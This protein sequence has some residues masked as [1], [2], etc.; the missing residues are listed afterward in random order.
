MRDAALDGHSLGARLLKLPAPLLIR[1]LSRQPRNAH[2]VLEPLH[3]DRRAPAPT[4]PRRAAARNERAAAAAPW[5]AASLA[6]ARCAAGSRPALPDRTTPPRRARPAARRAPHGRPAGSCSRSIAP[7][8]RSAARSGPGD[9]ASP[10]R[11]RRAAPPPPRP[12]ATRAPPPAARPSPPPPWPLAAPP[13]R[14]RAPR[15]PPPP[16]SASP[17]GTAAPRPSCAA[18][19]VRLRLRLR[20]RSASMRRPSSRSR[21]RASAPSASRARVSSCLSSP[22]AAS[23]WASCTPCCCRSWCGLGRGL[24]WGHRGGSMVREGSIDFAVL[25]VR[26]AH[27][28][29]RALD[30]LAHVQLVARRHALR[31]ALDVDVLPRAVDRVEDSPGPRGAASLA[32]QLSDGLR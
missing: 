31:L 16:R 29:H 8:R 3:L 21:R 7:P 24:G 18:P 11:R 9:R 1:Y 28:T 19:R 25:C 30:A 15:A 2:L 32:Q 6:P 17:A 13:R 27:L 12:R 10:A 22:M 14:A 4:P 20:V 23:S 5:L 26:L